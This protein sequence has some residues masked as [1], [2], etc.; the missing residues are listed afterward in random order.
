MFRLLAWNSSSNQILVTKTGICSISWVRKTDKQTTPIH[1]WQLTCT[2]LISPSIHLCPYLV[3]IRG[4]WTTDL[5]T[6]NRRTEVVAS[7]TTT[8]HSWSLTI[9]IS[10]HPQ[11]LLC[12]M[13]TTQLSQPKV[14]VNVSTFRS[15]S[16]IRLEPL[17]ATRSAKLAF[18]IMVIQH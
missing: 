2:V 12:Q 5:P 4:S 3:T 13:R 10:H 17:A 1:S 15:H 7:M 11:S 16:S 6:S 18:P 8:S 9:M 14:V